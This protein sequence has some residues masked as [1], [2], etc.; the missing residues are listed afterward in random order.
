MFILKVQVQNTPARGVNQGRT[1][2]FFVM[3]FQNANFPSGRCIC[4]DSGSVFY[5]LSSFASKLLGLHHVQSAERTRHFP[6]LSSKTD[7][8]I[9]VSNSLK[10]SQPLNAKR[11]KFE[12]NTPSICALGMFAWGMLLS[13]IIICRNFQVI[14]SRLTAHGL[15][16]YLTRA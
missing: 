7:V 16:R 5:L 6:P 13:G 10:K 9:R 11:T 1:L 2:L 12:N 14:D 4:I 8:Y 3:G 15:F